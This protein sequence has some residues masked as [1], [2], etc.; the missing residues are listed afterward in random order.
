MDEDVKAED[1]DGD[2]LKPTVN[3]RA[4]SSAGILAEPNRKALWDA[5]AQLSGAT[6][7]AK[8]G[9]AGIG[10]QTIAV[11]GI[12]GAPQVAQNSGWP[13]DVFG[14]SREQL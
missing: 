8:R 7:R 3:L 13:L 10:M 5:G 11:L 2:C 9:A 4:K 14:V 6:L 1:K 12:K